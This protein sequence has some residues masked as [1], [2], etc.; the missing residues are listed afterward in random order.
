MRQAGLGEIDLGEMM[1]EEDLFTSARK[2]ASELLD[3][4]PELNQP[5]HRVLKKF[6]HSLFANPTDV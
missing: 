2:Y 4:D 5:E 6:I 1:R 3:G